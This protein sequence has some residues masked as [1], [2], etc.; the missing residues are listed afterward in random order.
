MR[1][2]LSTR[3]HRGRRRVTVTLNA[4]AAG[5]RGS[6]QATSGALFVIFAVASSLSVGNT[7]EFAQRIDYQSAT[8]GGA[9]AIGS[10]NI[11]RLLL[12]LFRRTLQGVPVQVG[13]AVS[14]GRTTT[15][16]ERENE[17]LLAMPAT[18]PVAVTVRLQSG[19]RASGHRL[20]RARTP[21]S[22]Q[23]G[24]PPSE[25]WRAM[26]GAVRVGE[27]SSSQSRAFARIYRTMAS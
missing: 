20:S 4:L 24:G 21:I 9:L 12:L 10:R 7:T 1:V 17:A 18:G 15:R 16:G 25:C 2:S 13:R 8:G 19:E 5:W 27:L 11:A 26:D 23:P 6:T 14:T 3:V 22:G